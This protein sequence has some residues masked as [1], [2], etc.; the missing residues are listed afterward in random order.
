MM[1]FSAHLHL[2]RRSRGNNGCASLDI[3]KQ[4]TSLRSLV[5]REDRQAVFCI[6]NVVGI[7]ILLMGAKRARQAITAYKL[8]KAAQ[9]NVAARRRMR[10]KGKSK[11]RALMRKKV[12]NYKFPTPLYSN[13]NL[14]N[15]QTLVSKKRMAGYTPVGKFPDSIRVSN[16]TGA[17]SLA[18]LQG[19]AIL[20]NTLTSGDMRSAWAN[21]LRTSADVN[22]LNP[23]SASTTDRRVW[24]DYCECVSTI[25][26]QGPS[27]VEV[28][29][30][31]YVCRKDESENTIQLFIKG[32]DQAEGLDDAT[33][34]MVGALPSQS[35]LLNRHWKFLK[36]TRI[37]LA[38]GAIHRHSFKHRVNGAF[39][40]GVNFADGNQ[41]LG[42][43][44]TQ[45][46]IVFHGTPTDSEANR[47]IGTVTVAPTK[48]I[49]TNNQIYK[50]RLLNFKSRKLTQVSGLATDPFN[51][52]RWFNQNVD[53]SGV[54]DVGNGNT[55]LPATAIS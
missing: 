47:T 48:L 17:A 36:K 26:N 34:S 46:L 54:H 51:E 27:M 24:V 18:G 49:W 8:I 43:W 4:I 28:T 32:V 38:T 14:T 21:S 16:G 30:Y 10:A 39:N 44:T 12:A 50:T 42:G 33:A 22:V 23:L 29:L 5:P 41:N 55:I 53:G 45:T 20:A 2:H 25:T 13:G 9:K 15:T 31:D 19:A 11:P 40:L 6:G 37:N 7:R 52:E 1:S 35:L 3:Y